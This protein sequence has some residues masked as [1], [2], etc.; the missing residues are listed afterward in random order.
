[1][2]NTKICTFLLLFLFSASSPAKE[3]AA[4][5][6][7]PVYQ[8]ITEEAL[9][10]ISDFIKPLIQEGSEEFSDS[11]F[12]VRAQCAYL[13]WAIQIN[14]AIVRNQDKQDFGLPISDEQHWQTIISEHCHNMPLDNNARIPDI[15][16]WTLFT[17][18]IP[19][20]PVKHFISEMTELFSP[21]SSY[22]Q[23]MPSYEMPAL[24]DFHEISDFRERIILETLLLMLGR[25]ASHEP[26]DVWSR[27][28][29]ER[30][31]HVMS[32]FHCS[33]FIEN[34]KPDLHRYES[35]LSDL[36]DNNA[37]RSNQ[38]TI[39]TDIASGNFG[40]TDQQ[41]DSFDAYG[42]QP[43]FAIAGDTNTQKYKYPVTGYSVIAETITFIALLRGAYLR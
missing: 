7:R 26:T 21:F 6:L 36:S 38:A 43:G 2:K 23:N 28:Y 15:S 11:W 1:M 34:D 29:T 18:N 19:N 35:C 25:V 24:T 30:F 13:R 27:F 8:A 16:G 33:R 32:K 14:K 9:P 39:L 22:V 12:I 4:D 37:Q 42:Y 10:G 3:A 41:F 40:G 20:F 17:R 31:R 5:N